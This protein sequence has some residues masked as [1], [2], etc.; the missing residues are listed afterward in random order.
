MKRTKMNK[1]IVLIIVLFLLLSSVCLAATDFIKTPYEEFYRY[2][3]F[4][5]TDGKGWLASGE[6]ITTITS[7]ASYNK[8]SGTETTSTMISDT[9]ITDGNATASRVIYRI[10]AGTASMN[11]LIKIKIVTSAGRKFEDWVEF[12]V[13]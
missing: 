13:K 9:S 6:V 4:Y 1:T 5:R 10:K 7:I 3:D 2:H 8:I 12:A 11:Y